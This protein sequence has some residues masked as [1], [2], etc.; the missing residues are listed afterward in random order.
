ME[1]AEC[2]KR[3]EDAHVQS[4]KI[5]RSEIVQECVEVYEKKN[6]EDCSYEKL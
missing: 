3:D 5:K 6:K 1:I 2:I 4:I